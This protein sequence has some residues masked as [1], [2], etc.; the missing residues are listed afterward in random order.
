MTK[1]WLKKPSALTFLFT[2]SIIICIT[3]L[4]NTLNRLELSRYN[5]FEQLHLKSS[6][7]GL[8]PFSEYSIFY[9]QKS[10]IFFLEDTLES[11]RIV[12]AIYIPNISHALTIKINN[13]PVFERLKPKTLPTNTKSPLIFSFEPISS[14]VIESISMEIFSSGNFMMASNAYIGNKNDIL[15]EPYF[16]SPVNISIINI[17][18]VATIFILML[19]YFL[20]SNK[21]ISLF[22]LIFLNFIL[23]V[24]MLNAY[25]SIID[26]SEGYSDRSLFI[27]IFLSLIEILRT[28]I[29]DNKYKPLYKIWFVSITFYIFIKLTT[30]LAVTFMQSVNL[31]LFTTL[32][33]C[34]L[35]YTLCSI[36]K[37]SSQLILSGSLIHSLILA[38]VV[39]ILAD[40]L[41]KIGVLKSD[42]YLSTYLPALLL[43]LFV[44]LLALNIFK[45]NSDTFRINKIISHKVTIQ[46]KR[47]NEE[48]QKIILLTEDKLRAK[49]KS[50]ILSDLHDGVLS[51]LSGINLLTE[52]EQKNTNGILDIEKQKYYYSQQLSSIN[53][54]SRFATQEIR[55]ILD[56]NAFDNSTLFFTLSSLRIQVLQNLVMNGFRYKWDLLKIANYSSANRK[57]TLNMARI[58]QECIHNAIVRARCSVISIKAHKNEH[59]DHYIVISNIGGKSFQPNSIIQGNGTSN[60]KRRAKQISVNYSIKAIKGGARVVLQLPTPK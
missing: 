53:K 56:T 60:I 14:S 32:S 29:L 15:S 58:M 13:Q 21:K 34:L 6:E 46:K 17:S 50:D 12:D 55:L 48:N 7:I 41:L 1:S 54:L 44:G 22:P 43:I 10:E 52:I 23:L 51:Y 40:I 24:S 18:A 57:F 30:Q 59:G 11:N 38:V 49:E 9:N 27:L 4:A 36:K 19:V 35:F 28:S 37:I 3:L 47:I 33:M 5:N 2:I 20:F 25:E 8:L 31:L 16:F 26:N 45:A 42:F 39:I